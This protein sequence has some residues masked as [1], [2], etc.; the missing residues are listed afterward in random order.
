M[1]VQTI[2]N[3]FT[4]AMGWPEA[5]LGKATTDKEVESVQDLDV[6]VH[7]R[8]ADRRPPETES[9]QLEVGL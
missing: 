7:T 9:D 1:N 4:E 2:P 8:T 6:F 5:K 3:N